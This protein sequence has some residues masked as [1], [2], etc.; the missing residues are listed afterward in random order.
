MAGRNT[1]NDKRNFDRTIKEA[2]IGHRESQYEA[3]LMYA[4]G[5]GVAQDLKQAIHWVRQSAERGF[6]PAQYLLATRFGA[7]EVVAQDDHQALKWLIKA[8]D[9]NHPKAIY[10]LAKF[11]STTHT[12]AAGELC[13]AAANAGVPQAQ[14]DV[15]TEILASNVDESRA[16]QAFLWC[17][18]AAEQGVATAQCALADRYARGEGVALDVE[19]AYDWYRKAARQYHIAAQV[20]LSRL[21]DLGQGRGGERAS[22]KRFSAK[23]DRRRDDQRWIQAAHA[24]DASAKYN[25]GLMYKNGWGVAQDEAQCRAWFEAAAQTG[26]SQA[27]LVVAQM[28]ETELNFQQALVLYEKLAGL[29]DPLAFAAVG[30]FYWLGLGV[31]KNDFMALA[32]TIKAADFGQTQALSSLTQIALS[33]PHRITQ[34][35]LLKAANAGDLEAQYALGRHCE[36]AAKPGNDYT[37]TI[38]WYRS[39]AQ[40]GHPSAQCSLG[41]I[42]SGGSLV[43]KDMKQALEWFGKAAD[44]GDAK[45]LWNLA[46]LLSSGAEGVKKD[47]KKA[48]VLCKQSAD[49]GFVPAQATLAILY[50]KMKKSRDAVHWWN[51]AATAGDAESQFNLA[52]ALTEG[53][54]IEKNPHEAFKWFL[55][56]AEQGVLKAQSKVGLLYVTGTGVGLDMIEALKWFL[57]A[58]RRNDSSAQSNAAQANL[59]LDIN[60]VLEAERR[61]NA[62]KLSA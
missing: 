5:V 24:G 15:A 48:F 35:F 54:G 23:T 17:K 13:Q 18:K 58:G 26:H 52:V 32:H 9:Q 53:R 42:Y 33:E 39:A 6:A 1:V 31:Q 10:K 60:Q 16:E 57:I 20:A 40:Q 44:Q 3:A 12:R 61:A 47:L 50:A 2:R 11:Y 37:T 34:A 21:D 22:N 45:A 41:S 27:Q 30:R 29:G 46:L 8:A 62:W 59:N 14:L 49:Q 19:Q 38:Y 56:A 43:P 36:L 51:L 55:K 25:L 4:N 28:L 7:G